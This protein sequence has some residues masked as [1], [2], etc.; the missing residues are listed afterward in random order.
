MGHAVVAASI[1]SLV[2][3]TGCLEDNGE[4]GG[5]SIGGGEVGRIEALPAT[6][7][8][9]A[10]PINEVSTKTVIL[11]NTGAGV[12]RLN[13]IKLEENPEDDLNE[14]EPEGDWP[15]SVELESGESIALAVKWSPRNTTRD[16]G[17]IRIATNDSTAR[18]FEVPI[19]TPGLEPDISSP[20][21]V[22][23]PRV[24]TGETQRLLTS[25]TNSGQAPLQLK[26]IILS[27]VDATE[28]SVTFPTVGQESDPSQDTTT[29]ADV[30]APGE[31]IDVRVGFTPT[32]T[33]P[34]SA[35][36]IIDSND[37]DS[38]QYRV[39][40]SGNAGVPIIEL[41]GV[42]VPDPPTADETHVLNF[43]P[44]S[45]GRQNTRTVRI[46]NAGTERLDV[47]DISVVDDGGG[48]FELVQTSLPGGLPEESLELEPDEEAIFAVAYTPSD[49][50][51]NQGRLVVNSND[52]VSDQLKVDILG[53]GSTNACPIAVGEATIV[54]GSSNPTTQ[55]STIPLKTIQFDA[56]RSTDPGGSVQRYEWEVVQKPINS[57]ARL[58]PNNEDIRPRMFLDLA[59]DYVVELTVF[60][61]LNVPSCDTAQI[62]I[63]AQPDE[64]IHVQMVWETPADRDQTDIIGTDVDL[65]YLHPLG[66]WDKQPY[67]IYWNNKEADWGVPGRSDDNPSLDIDDTDGAG[68]ENV[69]HDNP[70]SGNTYRVGVYYYSDNGFGAS[71]VTVR[72]YIEG[73][74]KYE[75]RDKYL[76]RENVF[77]DVAG[78]VWPLKDIIETDTLRQGFPTR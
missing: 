63:R 66:S 20:R 16:T 8:F 54:D 30:I 14:F 44:S 4:N 40:L 41:G 25:I 37:P 6:I 26:R 52:P 33:N 69:N 46:R 29:W 12:L 42:D 27:P 24:P 19:T 45:I 1:I 74:I 13:S 3:L 67:D 5:G 75:K 60:D 34:A 64:D 31:K 39:S 36:I 9:D 10:T 61:D 56:S 55:I 18:N 22:Q 35:E 51:T 49:E 21:L 58:T 2:G 76:E 17:T 23:F 59:G 38:P 15:A 57:N 72:I 71:Y 73:T 62:F 43:G 65:H 7:N 28:F 47:D 78:V 68:P 48:V 53:V 77:W 32:S 11:E 70:E 50:V